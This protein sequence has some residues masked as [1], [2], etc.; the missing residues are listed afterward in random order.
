MK[1]KNFNNENKEL[2]SVFAA[3]NQIMDLDDT[4]V[5]IR[6]LKFIVRKICQEKSKRD[7]KR[8]ELN[9]IIKKFES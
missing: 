3:A 1:H 9:V 8:F 2:D 6:K 7:K 4:D 5:I